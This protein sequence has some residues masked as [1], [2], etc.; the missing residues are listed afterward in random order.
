MKEIK[1]MNLAECINRLR[2]LPDGTIEDQ[3]DMRDLPWIFDVAEELADRI[4][5]LTRWI[6]VEERLP[7]REDADAEGYVW[8]SAI[9]ITMGDRANDSWLWSEV[10]LDGGIAYKPTHWKRITPPEDK[11]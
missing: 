7:T 6:S 11:P 9:Q 4:H 8:V 5:D 10:S 3:F 2:E 1:D